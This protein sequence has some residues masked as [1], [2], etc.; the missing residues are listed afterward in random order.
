MTKYLLGACKHLSLVLPPKHYVQKY[1][2]HHGGSKKHWFAS[3]DGW[4]NN[5]LQILVLWAFFSLQK[6]NCPFWIFKYSHKNLQWCLQPLVNK[7]QEI[8]LP[9]EK[10]LYFVQLNES[11]LK[12]QNVNFRSM[13]K[14]CSNLWFYFR[15]PA[16][17]P[18]IEQI[19]GYRI[20]FV[21]SHSTSPSA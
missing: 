8:L 21:W 1:K 17:S 9:P 18:A 6:I 19:S 15:L 14:S 12:F 5:L 7:F 11:F 3:T 10:I 4:W 2:T 13:K 16:Q 20:V